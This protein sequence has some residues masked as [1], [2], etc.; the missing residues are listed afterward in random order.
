MIAESVQERNARQGENA[1]M[2]EI[3]KPKSRFHRK[4]IGD[5]EVIL[6]EPSDSRSGFIS[7]EAALRLIL[8]EMIVGGVAAKD[9]R[10]LLSWQKVRN[11]CVRVQLPA[12]EYVGWNF[13]F[14]S[15]YRDTLL[16]DQLP[17]TVELALKLN[18][19]NVA[20]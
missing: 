6:D 11:V 4:F 16:G 9:K 15:E 20:D 1:V 19:R 12:F 2:A 8:T 13:D 3:I 14:A 17:T 10:M 18:R 5:G 7:P